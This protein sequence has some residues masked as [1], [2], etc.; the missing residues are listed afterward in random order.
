MAHKHALDSPGR[1]RGSS[2][3][4]RAIPGVTRAIVALLLP[5]L[6]LPAC[7]PGRAPAH[8]GGPTGPTGEDAATFV[9]IHGA[10]GGG[11]AW[12]PVAERL[13]QAGHVTH[14]PTLTGLGERVHLAGPDVDLSTHIDDVVHHLVFERLEDVVLVGHSYGGMVAMGVVHRVPER[15]R[16]VVLLDAFLP[17]DGESGLMATRGMPLEGR[18]SAL[19]RGA[20]DG[21][22]IPSWTRP[23]DPWPTDVPHPVR[24]FTE[25]I[26]MRSPAAADVPGTYILTVA[27]GVDPA[28]D[29]YSGFAARAR[30]LGWEVLILRS[31]HN[32]QN[33]ARA[34]LAALLLEIS[35][36][37]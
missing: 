9:V 34:E 28:A 15:I 24:T 2:G 35:R 27:P 33:S 31:D 17:A 14:R 22:I 11:W 26:T 1:G 12:A 37:R 3:M 4:I 19:V 21:L 7:G 25:P 18:I 23:D 30:D 5:V 10:W 20:K 8:P 13:R 36:D 32:P 29:D 6:L 16:R